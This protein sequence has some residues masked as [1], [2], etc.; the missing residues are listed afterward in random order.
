MVNAKPWRTSDLP[1]DVLFIW[2]L[3]FSRHVTL[4]S[5]MSSLSSSRWGRSGLSVLLRRLQVHEW[6]L[7]LR[8][9][10]RFLCCFTGDRQLLCYMLYRV[11]LFVV[12]SLARLLCKSWRRCCV[13]QT[14]LLL[15]GSDSKNDEPVCLACDPSCLDCRGPSTHNCTVCPALQIL[16]DDGRCLSCCGN[17]TRHDN[18]PISRECCDCTV[19]RGRR[20]PTQTASKTH[21]DYCIETCSFKIVCVCVCVC[22]WVNRAFLWL[23]CIISCIYTKHESHLPAKLEFLGKEN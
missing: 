16:S 22:A 20:E 12:H 2:K 1:S 6:H 19:S 8:V 11:C 7:W 14:C 15:Q 18:K 17:E 21:T 5:V 23:S 4:F 3:H 10:H 9:S 13:W